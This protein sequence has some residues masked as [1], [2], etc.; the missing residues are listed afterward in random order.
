MRCGWQEKPSWNGIQNGIRPPNAM[1]V[2]PG[3]WAHGWQ[4]H[5]C[6]K[7][8]QCAFNNLLF[9]KQRLRLRGSYLPCIELVWLARISR[10][11]LLA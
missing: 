7:L 4:Y 2:E 11:R 9:P 8:E 6:D 1:E 10:C 5:A 3:A